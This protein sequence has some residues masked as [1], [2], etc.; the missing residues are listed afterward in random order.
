[1]PVLWT[2]ITCVT[3][4][5][6][7]TPIMSEAAWRIQRYNILEKPCN[8]YPHVQFAWLNSEGFRDQFTFTKRNEMKINTKRNNFLKEA[9]DYN[10][11]R[12]IVDKQSRGFTT[13]SQ[14]IKEDW[15]AT[16]G[17]M[18]DEEVAL[19]ES[20]FKSPSVNVR[21]STG[22]YANE[23]IP[24]NIVSSSYTEKSYRKDRLFQYTVNYKL[25][26]NIK[27]QRG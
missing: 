2:P 19:I 5:Q 6:S 11:T 15:T 24:I 8:D 3:D 18:N 20:M 23:W 7:Q 13:Y 1:V 17:Y 21:F 16:S 10:D 27:S 25:A 4:E 14:S 26:N 12:Y 22:E 9:A